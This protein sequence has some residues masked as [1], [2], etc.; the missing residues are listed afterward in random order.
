MNQISGPAAPGA[1]VSQQ[2]PQKLEYTERGWVATIPYED[3]SQSR[4]LAIAGSAAAAGARVMM[5][6]SFGKTRIETVYP[7]NF[8]GGTPAS[9][10]VP[11]WEMISKRAEVSIFSPF[12][13]LAAN[14]AQTNIQYL[15]GVIQNL[16]T[17]T[18][19]GGTTALA[20]KDS[21]TQNAALELL[22][23]YLNDVT[24]FICFVPELKFTLTVN[25]QY[26]A[27][28]SASSFANVGRIFSSSTLLSYWNIPFT[29][30]IGFPFVKSIPSTV[31]GFNLAWGWFT[32]GPEVRQISDFKFQIVQT[33]EWGLW[34]QDMYGNLL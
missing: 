1:M 10:Y 12:N 5:T 25:G 20:W 9:E 16:S 11:L 26:A 22:G 23:L 13:P 6:S 4:I 8:N 34:S 28:A 3:T 29:I 33:W 14:V 32:N 27:A 24:N 17:Y 31:W 7:F 18:I 19:G 2:Q 21:G 15:K 30:S